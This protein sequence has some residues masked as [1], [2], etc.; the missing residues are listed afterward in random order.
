[1]KIQKSINLFKTHLEKQ[2]GQKKKFD[3]QLQKWLP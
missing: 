1:M 3:P 2:K